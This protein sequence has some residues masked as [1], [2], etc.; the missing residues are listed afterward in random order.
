M[1]PEGTKP[2]VLRGPGGSGSR[3][4]RQPDATMA[5]VNA[6]TS[7]FRT[8]SPSTP[9][10][11]SLARWSPPTQRGPTRPKPPPCVRIPRFWCRCAHKVASGGRVVDKPVIVFGMLDGMVE[12]LCTASQLARLAA[13]GEILDPAP[14]S[15]WDDP[16]AGDLLAGAEILVGHW[17]CPT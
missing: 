2:S 8:C 13:C 12:H 1:Y 3:S 9:Q 17:G 6:T 16:R 15:S 5:T 7:D 10:P 4:T 11:E 14:L